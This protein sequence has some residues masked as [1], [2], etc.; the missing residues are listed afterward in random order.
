MIYVIYCNDTLQ[1]KTF[2]SPHEATTDCADW[3]A[4]RRGALV[5]EG[6]EH[7]VIKD[8]AFDTLGGNAVSLL[9]YLEYFRLIS[10]RG[11]VIRSGAM[12]FV[13]R[14]GAMRFVIRS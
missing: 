9:K 8:C 6:A 14:S 1:A 11:F 3:A 7:I 4:P 5:L 13:I 12:R 2:L 10:S